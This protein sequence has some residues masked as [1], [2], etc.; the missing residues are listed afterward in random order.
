MTSGRRTTVGRRALGD[1][2]AAVE[3]DDALGDP[4]HDLHDVL[5][6]GD[7]G[8]APLGQPLQQRGERERLAGRQPGDDLVEQDQ[9]R[10][11]RE[12]A[13]DLE[14]L[15]RGEREA[16]GGQSAHRLHLEELQHLA[17]ALGGLGDAGGY[18]GTRRASRSRAR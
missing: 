4:H 14:P 8:H 15:E 11:G 16:V 1:Q 18:G 3:H 6:A 5:D 13:G 7:R 9:L 12:R 17:G 2:R 10:P